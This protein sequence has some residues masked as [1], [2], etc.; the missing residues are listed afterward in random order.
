LNQ[1]QDNFM[2]SLVV[3]VEPCETGASLEAFAR[4]LLEGKLRQSVTL[5]KER[6]AREKDPYTEFLTEH[7][8]KA[9]AGYQYIQH[10]IHEASFETEQVRLH[11][12]E[13]L[14]TG[15]VLRQ[16]VGGASVVPEGSWQSPLLSL[17]WDERAARELLTAT[18]H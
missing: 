3:A 13:D 17:P 18:G 15:E 9:K 1:P 11:L 14:V 4:H 5:G 6:I 16:Q 10:L 8:P 2:A 12:E 7:D